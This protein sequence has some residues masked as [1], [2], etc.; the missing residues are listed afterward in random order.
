MKGETWDKS[1][2]AYYCSVYVGK[3]RNEKEK[4]MQSRVSGQH[5]SYTGNSERCLQVSAHGR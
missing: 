3:E 4:H 5:V 2:N 1:K